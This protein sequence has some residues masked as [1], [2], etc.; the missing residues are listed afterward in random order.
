MRNYWWKCSLVAAEDPSILGMSILWDDH[1][2]QLHQWSCVSQGLECY[3]GQCWRSEPSS[4]EEARRS[5]MEPRH[6]SKKLCSWCSL[7]R[8]QDVKDSRD[9]GNLPRTVSNRKW[10]QPKRKNYVVVNKDERRCR[11][12]ECFDIRHGDAEFEVRPA[13]FWSSIFSL[14]FLP[15]V[16]Q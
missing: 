11:S 1:Q 2:E 8:Y 9:M 16:L 15:Y 5:R 7:W 14:C 4:L 3:T 6:W 10:I 12:E 13:G